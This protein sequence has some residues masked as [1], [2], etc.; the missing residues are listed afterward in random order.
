MGIKM[1]QKLTKQEK[2][3]K[4][5][6]YLAKRMK[7]QGRGKKR[8]RKEHPKVKRVRQIPL[9]KLKRKADEV[10]GKF[11]RERDAYQGCYAM[12]VPEEASKCK[13]G[14]CCCHLF[15]RS[16]YDIRWDEYNGNG[17]CFY[18][19]QIHDHT[20]RPKPHIYTG[21][22]IKKH[23]FEKYEELRQRSYIKHTSSWIRAKCEEVIKK[24]GGNRV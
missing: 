4:K 10:F 5:V 12:D 7:T 15:G 11:V 24:Y 17:G 3:D 20:F 2:Y 9:P 23:G 1:G 6:E 16:C 19:N 21:W 8:A 14:W 18:H 22:F 13:S